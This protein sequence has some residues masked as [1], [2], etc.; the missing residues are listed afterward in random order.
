MDPERVK[1]FEALEEEMR[2]IR[3]D[4]HRLS[5]RLHM[6]LATLKGLE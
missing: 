2:L 6:A 3:D 5:S 4:Q 1:T